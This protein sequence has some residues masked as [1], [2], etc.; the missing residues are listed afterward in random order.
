MN[1]F[2]LYVSIFPPIRQMN[3]DLMQFKIIELL[4]KS[5][6]SPGNNQK[7]ITNFINASSHSNINE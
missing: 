6:R 1:I 2:E 7:G 3:T 4:R 5:A